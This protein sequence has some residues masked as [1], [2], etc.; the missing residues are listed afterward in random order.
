VVVTCACGHGRAW[1]SPTGL[2]CTMRVRSVLASNG[3]PM[4]P[5]VTCLCRGYSGRL[6]PDRG[7]PGRRRVAA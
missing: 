1:H 6:V 4:G 7:K 5:I 2:L 3:R